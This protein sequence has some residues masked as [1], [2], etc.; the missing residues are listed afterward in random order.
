MHFTMNAKEKKKSHFSPSYN[1]ISY[2]SLSQIST[3]YCIRDRETEV[4]R[5]IGQLTKITNQPSNSQ[6][7]TRVHLN[8]NKQ[9]RCG[10]IESRVG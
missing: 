7:H 4:M 5:E 1:F 2:L 3:V 8:L 9:G 6:K 10:S